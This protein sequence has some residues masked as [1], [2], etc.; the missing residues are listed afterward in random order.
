MWLY[1]VRVP[2]PVHAHL[3]NMFIAKER[4]FGGVM[5]DTSKFDSPWRRDG[6]LPDAPELRNGS[7]RRYDG[8]DRAQPAISDNASD[9]RSNRPRQA[10]SDHESSSSRR[11]GSGFWTPDT[12]GGA[13]DKDEAWQIGSKFK[14]SNVPPTEGPSRVSNLRGISKEQSSVDEGDWRAARP[15]SAANSSRTRS[16][17]CHQSDFIRFISSKQLRSI[18]AANG[19]QK[20]GA[21]TSFRKCVGQS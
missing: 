12:H 8:A 16:R 5:D 3:L 2:I 14:P 21:S 10:S 7:R 1:L 15:R 9:W 11:R 4:T 13:A 19:A 18:H 17:L 20:I 6:P